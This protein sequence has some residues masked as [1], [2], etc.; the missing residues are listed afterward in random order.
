MH[1]KLSEATAAIRLIII[2]RLTM[3]KLWLV[4]NE[5]SYAWELVLSNWFVFL[6]YENTTV[7]NTKTI[8]LDI[9][10]LYDINLVELGIFPYH[11]CESPF[12]NCP[13][14]FIVRFCFNLFREAFDFR[15]SW[16]SVRRLCHETE[17]R[18]ITSKASLLSFAFYEF[19]NVLKQPSQ[20]TFVV[21]GISRNAPPLS[22]RALRDM[23]II[24]ESQWWI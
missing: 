18:L 21:F 7:Y 10:L 4:F 1:V 12:T 14:W 16:D 8:P 19:L 5:P 9:L 15:L 13:K 20:S 24:N 22:G 3:E 11:S 2:N 17:R 6:E 23:P